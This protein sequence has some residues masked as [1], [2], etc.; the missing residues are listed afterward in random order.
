MH[1]GNPHRDVAQSPSGPALALALLLLL[2]GPSCGG[3]AKPPESAP[4]PGA[5]HAFEGSG[6]AAGRGQTLQMDGE[7]KVSIFSLSGPLL[8]AG[9][10][11]I[12][13]GFR[14]EAIGYAESGKGTVAWCVWTD[15]RGD[16][17]F[18]EVRG[19]AIGTGRR[20]AGTL[21]GGTGRYAG[22]TGEYEYEWQFVV[23]ADDGSIQGRITGLKGRFLQGPPPPSPARNAS[24]IPAGPGPV[25]P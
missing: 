9:E 18:S 15:S 5:W 25:R 1:R 17:V 21:Q 11:R 6:T 13:E 24:G 20:F 19:G 7:R 12:G 14:C 3:P 8:I 2:S 16:K 4:P 10:R 22:A 23:A